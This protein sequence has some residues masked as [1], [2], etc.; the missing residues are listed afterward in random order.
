MYLTRI[1]SPRYLEKRKSSSAVCNS[2]KIQMP[3]LPPAHHK[4]SIYVTSIY[5]GL[6]CNVQLNQSYTSLP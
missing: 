3:L 6:V 2:Y 5:C 4:I 1:M